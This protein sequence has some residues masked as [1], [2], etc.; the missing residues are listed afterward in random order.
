MSSRNIPTTPLVCALLAILIAGLVPLAH[1]AEGAP[2]TL[3]IGD[4]APTLEVEAWL[5]GE[6]VPQFMRGHAYIVDFWATWCLPC[7]YGMPH[8]TEMQSRWA[9]RVTVIGVDVFEGKA[10]AADSATTRERVAAFVAARD[11]VI[12][13]RI[14]LDGEAQKAATGWLRAAGLNTIPSAFLVDGEGRIAHIGNP[15]QP[16]FEQAVQ[17]VLDGSHDLAAARV[18]YEAEREQTKAKASARKAASLR[19]D[20]AVATALPHIR[21]GRN[22][23]GV[24]VLD[25]L[26]GVFDALG[27]TARDQ[28]KVAACRSLYAAGEL[29]V[30]DAYVDHLLAADA[31]ASG[32]E[33]NE[34][35]WIMVNPDAPVAGADPRR[36]LRCAERALAILEPD[37]QMYRTTIMEVQARSLWQ[38]GERE[39]AVAVLIEAVAIETNE[40]FRTG[41]QELLADYTR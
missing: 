20:A 39:R 25:T 9:D 27:P 31:M 6:P 35:A 5:K 34:I 4:N 1:A 14:A 17:A 26:D 33:L 16:A 2:T 19:L 37:A 38:A 23:D 3:G 15:A 8:L 29:A 40:R 24:A 36:A 13:Y 28:A 21:A 12:G 22:G 30:A 7:V 11:S 18:A 10:D 41:L 32:L